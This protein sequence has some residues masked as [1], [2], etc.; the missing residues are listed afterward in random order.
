MEK[1]GLKGLQYFIDAFTK[2]KLNSNNIDFSKKGFPYTS[3][4]YKKFSREKLEPLFTS[5]SDN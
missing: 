1:F 2:L 4:Q 3:S 5:Y